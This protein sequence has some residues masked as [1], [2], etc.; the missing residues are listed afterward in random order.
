MNEIRLQPIGVIHSPHTVPEKTPI[1]PSFATGIRGSAEIDPAY[2]TGLTDVEGF[3]HLWLLY[4]LDRVREV[5]L[6]V[7]PYLEDVAHGVFATRAPHRP[8]P[9]GL[10]LVRLVGRSGCT[11]E[12]EDVDVLDGT[13]L[14]DI[15]PYVGRFDVR[16]NARSGWL[17]HV[18]DAAAQR[19]GRRQYD[20]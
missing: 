6:S 13:P 2:A 14:L 8:N 1:Q 5:R 4:I 17:E 19:R 7:T 16:P 12:L 3:S 15:K 10:S 9:I 18:E 20:G 11:L